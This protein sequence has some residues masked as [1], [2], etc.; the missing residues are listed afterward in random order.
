[1]LNGLPKATM[2]TGAESG[3][4]TRL[5]EPQSY[6]SDIKFSFIAT[7]LSQNKRSTACR[8]TKKSP[9][10]PEC[11]TI[12]P[13]SVENGAY[14][15][16]RYLQWSTPNGSSRTLGRLLIRGIFYAGKNETKIQKG[17]HQNSSF[18][19]KAIWYY[20]LLAISSFIWT[21][22]LLLYK[23]TEGHQWNKFRI[24]V[25]AMYCDL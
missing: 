6:A 3:I 7:S 25:P 15:M 17:N 2:D 14:K 8:E 10:L 19:L 5:P 12:C 22:R 23:V 11:K 21:K 9:V 4:I 13:L 16:L 20:Y 24:K 1:M 18:L